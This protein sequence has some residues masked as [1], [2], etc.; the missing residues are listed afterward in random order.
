MP[1]VDSRNHP[2]FEHAQAGIVLLIYEVLQIFVYIFQRVLAV[3][4]LL[5]EPR[6]QSYHEFFFLLKLL[7]MIRESHELS[8]TSMQQYR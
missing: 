7:T 3:K 2:L 6:S 8:Q 5:E 1:F 4:Y